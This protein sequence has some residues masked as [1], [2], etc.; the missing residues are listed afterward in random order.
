MKFQWLGVRIFEESTSAAIQERGQ[1][2][3]FI[4]TMWN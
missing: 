4:V 1:G 3:N 2:T